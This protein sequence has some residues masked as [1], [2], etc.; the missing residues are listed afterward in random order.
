[1]RS[2]SGMN[3]LQP[4]PRFQAATT[5]QP[6]F[7]PVMQPGADAVQFGG[8]NTVRGGIAAVAVALLLA[9]C[10]SWGGGGKS[11]NSLSVRSPG[12]VTTDVHC[13]GNAE[14]LQSLLNKNGLSY[15]LS[16]G[17]CDG[18]KFNNQ[19]LQGSVSSAPDKLPAPPNTKGLSDKQAKFLQAAYKA[20]QVLQQAR[21]AG[22]SGITIIF[23]V[24]GNNVS[25]QYLIGTT[26]A[27]AKAATPKT[28]FNAGGLN[29]DQDK[30]V[31]A[32]YQALQTLQVAS[33]Q[34][35]SGVTY[36]FQTDGGS[37]S[38]LQVSN[39]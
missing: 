21:N 20:A 9:G 36:I 18:I 12:A 24:D 16:V 5:A 3:P 15:L 30:A 8:R 17:S 10:S 13:V 37:A 25:A 23:N 38:L 29:G 1:M 11:T 35:S 34:G 2:V 14:D 28:Q 27:A 7:M 19:S 6:A 32:A 31:N 22:L 26:G 39:G 4:M 33:R